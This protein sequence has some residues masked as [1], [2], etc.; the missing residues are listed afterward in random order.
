M[1]LGRCANKVLE[2][3]DDVLDVFV[4]AP[5]DYRI[6]FYKDEYNKDTNVDAEKEVKKQDSI[7]RKY[8]DHFSEYEWGAHEG[9]DLMVDS[10]IMGPE[11]TTDFLLD[12]VERVCR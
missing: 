5:L 3:H 7:R 4:Y 2:N 9:Y 6:Q 1:I 11:G 12:Y 10:S 8:Y